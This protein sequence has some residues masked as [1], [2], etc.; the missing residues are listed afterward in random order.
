VKSWLSSL[1]L[2]GLGVLAG[3]LLVLASERRPPDLD[4][5]TE[6]AAPPRSGEPV[7]RI[8][9]DPNAAAE[10]ENDAVEA[11]EKE[12]TEKSGATGTDSSTP[13]VPASV[14]LAAP[15]SPAPL[16][17]VQ[18]RQRAAHLVPIPPPE[19]GTR[20]R[21]GSSEAGRPFERPAGRAA[22]PMPSHAPPQPATGRPDIAGAA[23]A[24]DGETLEV[25]GQRLRLFGIGAPDLR[26]DCTRSDG[27]RWRCGQEARAGLA[28]LLPA[29]TNVRCSPRAEDERGQLLAVCFDPQGADLAARQVIGG[30]AL[31]QRGVA[32]DYVDQETI[33]RTARRGMWNGDFERPWEWKS[34]NP[35]P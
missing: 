32:L 33:A 21:A 7:V 13:A 14:A 19:P 5:A 17:E 9:I 22:P 25:A 24:I 12:A 3:V 31:A 27:G 6:L 30:H 26:Q 34:N 11:A 8:E 28:Q 20:P 16:P 1:A 35:A 18:V 2:F 10:E 15:A 4:V 23:R 29:G